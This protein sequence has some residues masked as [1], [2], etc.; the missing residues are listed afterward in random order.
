MLDLFSR[1]NWVNDKVL[2][3]SR[4]EI[5]EQFLN[6]LHS[7]F[8]ILLVEVLEAKLLILDQH[9]QIFDADAGFLAKIEL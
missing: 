5:F 6:Y 3:P 4:G 2:F 1:T 9:L 8:I 7:D